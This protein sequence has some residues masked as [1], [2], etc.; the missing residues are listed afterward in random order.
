MR[1][2]ILNQ[3]YVPDLS[4]T[5]HLAASLARHRAETGDDVTVI[6]GRS[7]YASEART[8]A[9]EGEPPENLRL[10]R[11]WTPGLGKASTFRRLL[12]YACFYAGALGRV[13]ALPR[14]DAIVAMTT[15]PFLVLAALAH[16]MFRRR[17]RVILWMMDC[18]PEA[19]EQTGLVRPGGRLSRLLR[20]LSRFVLGRV[21]RIVCPDSAMAD[22]LAARYGPEIEHELPITVIPNWESADAFPRDLTPPRWPEA[23]TLGLED[24]LVVLYFGNMGYGHRF[25]AVLEAAKR[26]ENEPV[27]FLFLGGGREWEAVRRAASEANLNN[28]IIRDYVPKSQTPAVLGA[29]DV[30]LITLR[31][32]VAGV[33]SPSKLH[34]KLAMGLPVLY[35]GPA[36]SNVD[37][38]ITSFDCGLSAREREVDRVVAWLRHLLEDSTARQQ[39]SQRAR[40]AFAYAY[41]D[42]QALTAFDTVL[43][44]ATRDPRL[45]LT[46]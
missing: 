38:A 3:Y 27:T 42:R 29:A 19:A 26:L 39:L 45:S 30:G 12:D 13:L 7:G 40:E 4:P 33:M 25:E 1:L 2:T 8:D 36:G 23:E 5:A 17:T 31:E 9:H 46:G 6:A 21:D 15:P 16:K 32:E 20:R 24:R 41:S 28:V 34:A 22:L 35:L 14:Q 43:T 10:I 18:Y 44:D 11:V 37:E